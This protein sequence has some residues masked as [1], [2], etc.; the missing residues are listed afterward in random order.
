MDDQFVQPT[1]GWT[2]KEITFALLGFN[3]Y[4]DNFEA[5]SQTIR[6]LMDARLIKR[7]F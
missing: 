1:T 7:A 3:K 4:G 2:Q 5:I 6:K